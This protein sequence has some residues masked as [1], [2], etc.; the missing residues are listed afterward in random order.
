MTRRPLPDVLERERR[1]RGIKRNTVKLDC[2]ADAEK[3]NGC[4]A[5]VPWETDLE[6]CVCNHGWTGAPELAE[7]ALT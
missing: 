3:C 6:R 1:M 5:S 4:C 7:V 2:I